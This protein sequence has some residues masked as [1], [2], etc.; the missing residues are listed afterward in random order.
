MPLNPVCNQVIVT[1]QSIERTRGSYRYRS[2]IGSLKR[3]QKL[4]AASRLMSE[5]NL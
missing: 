3:V 5:G 4:Q 1:R 2:H